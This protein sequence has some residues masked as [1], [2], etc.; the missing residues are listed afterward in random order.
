MY[1]PEM[2]Q[3][4]RW[5]SSS[6]EMSVW[7]ASRNSSLPVEG[8]GPGSRNSYNQGNGLFDIFLYLGATF[9]NW[10]TVP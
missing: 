7:P 6:R 5:L 3:D 2:T 10:L 8:R 9:H 1:A 4:I